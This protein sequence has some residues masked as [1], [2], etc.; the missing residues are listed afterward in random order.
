MRGG[1]GRQAGW[2]VS[3]STIAFSGSTCIGEGTISYVFKGVWEVA[4]RLPPDP[5]PP[6]HSLSTSSSHF[7]SLPSSPTH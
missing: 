3:G 7:T 2:F 4:S 5:T 6:D 1:A